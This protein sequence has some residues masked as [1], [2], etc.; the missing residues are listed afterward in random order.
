MKKAPSRDDYIGEALMGKWD[1][2]PCSQEDWKQELPAHVCFHTYSSR[3]KRKI[4]AMHRYPEFDPR[5]Q[6]A[7]ADL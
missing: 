4:P 2:R 3:V 7:E 5:S 1:Y 6:K